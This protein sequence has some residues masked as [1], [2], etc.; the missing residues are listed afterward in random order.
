MNYSLLVKEELIANA[1]RNACC[2]RA[3]TAGLLFDLR[4]WRE[5]CLVLVLSSVAARRE[6]ARAYREQYRRE[7]LMDGSVMLFSSEKLFAHYKELPNFACKKCRS[8]FLRGLAIS[9]GSVTDPEKGTHLEFRISNAEK[10]PV[11]ADFFEEIGWN[12]KSRKI[13]FGA[14]FY[15]KQGIEIEEILRTVGASNA[16]FAFM[17]AKIARGIRNQENRA[18]NCVTR[19]IAKAVEASRK[20]CEAI[21]AICAAGRFEALAEELRETAELRLAHPDANLTELAALHNPPIT[22]SGLNHRLQKIMNAATAIEEE[23]H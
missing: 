5:G 23:H 15:T 16:L 4:E 6:C 1:P 7:A 10:I 13:D 9:C 22:K 17:N 19:N 8:N 21:E 12:L 11:L 14:G 20:C 2:K 18:T 3:Y